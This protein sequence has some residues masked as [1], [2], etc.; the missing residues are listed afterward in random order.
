[1]KEGNMAKEIRVL[2]VEDDFYA[3]NWMELLLRRDWRTKVAREVGSPAELSNA[4]EDINKHRERVDLILIDTDIPHD[5]NWLTDTLRSLAKHSPNTAILFTSV[6]PNIQVAKLLSQSNFAGYILKDE[7]RYSLAWAV[8]LAAEHHIVVT[9][10]VCD[11]FDKN[12]PLPLGTLILNGNNP[13]AALSD[14]E[15]KRSRM[16]FIFSMERHEFADEEEISEDFSY[17]VVSALYKKLGL[18]DILEGEA[19]PEQFF[20]NHPAVLSHLKQTLEHLKNSKSKKAKDKETLAFHL[21]TLPDIDE[22]S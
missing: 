6:S 20:G 4:L 18:N 2:L 10:G 1:V 17:G 16:V 12:N 15:D 13:I 21:L 7:I 8:S 3:R 9:P 19:E 22:I 14:L 5:M 11:V